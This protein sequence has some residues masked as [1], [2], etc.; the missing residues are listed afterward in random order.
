MKKA[1]YLGKGVYSIPEVSNLTGISTSHIRRWVRGYRLYRDSTV[2]WQSL[3]FAPDYQAIGEK[4]AL[5]FL[6]LIEVQFIAWFR[7]HEVS[8]K[9]IRVAAENAA[10][11]LE[12][13]HPFAK[14]SFFTDGKG[15]L[16]RIGES[17]GEHELINLVSSQYEMDQLVCPLLYENLD[18]G[19]MDVANRWWPRGRSAGIV[20]D[21]AR[22]M[23]KPVVA[24]W[25]IPTGVLASLFDNVGSI[26]RVADWY[27]ID[28]EAV[29]QAVEFEHRSAA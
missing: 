10:K 18:F 6:D 9:A 23:G 2:S 20:V 27:E 7:R 4:F 26:E 12:F 21:P 28:S 11:L 16:A 29:R 17:S 8:W 22:N 5:S 14:R 25:N 19:E 24:K 3:V 1:K 13:G 15:I